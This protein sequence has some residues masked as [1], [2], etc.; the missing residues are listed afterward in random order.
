MEMA[1]TTAVISRNRPTGKA[2]D[3]ASR[4]LRIWLALFMVIAAVAVVAPADAAEPLP[5]TPVRVSPVSRIQVEPSIAINPTNPQNLVAGYIDGLRCGVAWSV[6]SGMTWTTAILA[7]STQAAF[8]LAG[9]PVVDFA[10]DGTA[11]YLCMNTAGP[12]VKTQ[13]LYRSNDGGMTWNDTNPS[14][15]IAPTF[16]NDD[17]GHFVVDNY[18]GSPFFGNI[19]VAATALGS[20][21]VRFVRSADG[22]SVFS[23]PIT[24]NDADIGF[25]VNLA[26][27]ADGT[28]Y[29][30]WE[31]EQTVGS[32]IAV[33]ID[34][35][36]DGGQNF[37]ALTG[38]IDA[39]IQ[40][41]GITLGGVRPIPSRGNGFPYIGTHPTDPNVVYAVWAESGPG[42]DDSDIRFSRSTDRGD[43][44]S[45]SVRINTDVNPVGDF[46]SQFWP[47]M[48][49]DPVDGDINI[50]WYSDQNDPDRTAGAPFIDLYFTR[51]SDSGLTFDP[52]VLVTPAPS[53]P[54]NFF[55]D[56]LGIDA[57]GGVA[58]PIWIDTTFGTGTF[59]AATT[60]I[61]AANLAIT[62]TD[63]SDPAVAGT[64]VTYQLTITN[65]GPAQARDIVVTGQ[66]PAGTTLASASLSCTPTLGNSIECP[67]SDALPAGMSTN[68][69]LTLDIVPSLVH[70]AGSAVTLTN[71]ASVKSSQPDP[72]LVDNSDTETTTV[73]AEVDLAVVSL[74]TVGPEVDPVVG[75][76]TTRDLTAVV[77]NSGP[78]G[79][80]DTLVAFTA[81]SSPGVSVALPSTSLTIPALP[82][83]ELR[84]AEQ[85]AT[86]TCDAPGTHTITFEATAAPDEAAT[87]DPSP[88]NNAATEPVTVECQVPVAV[89]IHPGSSEN[90]INV[91]S[92]G[93]VPVAVLTTEAGE[94]GLPMAFDATSI[95]VDT[96]RFGSVDALQSGSGA[97][98]VHKRGH[99]EDSLELDEVTYDGD[100][101]LV[102]HFSTAATAIDPGTT[103]VC[104]RGTFQHGGSTYQFIGCDRIDLLPR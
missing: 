39:E 47:T 13:Y 30:A 57:Y 17:K 41:T 53:S 68:L 71:E 43:T 100:I 102:L 91:R 33:R 58:H 61:G 76:S 32:S 25:A 54:S 31:A 90:P 97:P 82:A 44:W 21:Q 45:P 4:I 92:G 62:M 85:T 89:N 83:G 87:T 6:D 23:T 35:S 51:S 12:N 5:G 78:S 104:V 3:S 48:A 70:D 26:V 11:Y 101:D 36:D 73:V 60:Q 10:A 80:V 50:I 29:A 95:Y 77:T 66:L 94:Y 59:D 40:S 19:Y 67:M 63:V 96:V 28:V 49:V 52:P 24:I 18:P 46:S 8:T 56:Y 64:S 74:T 99:L 55:G 37:G 2:L 81:T 65:S 84:T 38:G 34:R 69:Q 27:G 1:H 75:A 86:F 93:A 103:E 79:P 20:G 16:A 72:V 98:T 88:G 42:T 7:E 9:D 14:L 15:A 22:G